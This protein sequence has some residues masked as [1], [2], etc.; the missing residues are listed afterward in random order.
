MLD[1]VFEA[2]VD[3][4]VSQ[5]L[6]LAG[7]PDAFLMAAKFLKV[8]AGANGSFGLVIGLA[9]VGNAEKLRRHGAHM[10]VNDLADLL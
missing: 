9:R 5:S 1:A 2:Q 4:A 6:K 7:K 10:V 8:E 3:G